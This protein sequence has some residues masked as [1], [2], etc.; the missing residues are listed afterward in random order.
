MTGKLSF[1]VAMGAYVV[2]AALASFTLD[3][4]MLGAV[5]LLLV[6]LAVKTWIQRIR[7]SRESREN[8]ENQ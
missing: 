3:G 5:L 2:L 6:A 8:H 7:E 4:P 1:Q